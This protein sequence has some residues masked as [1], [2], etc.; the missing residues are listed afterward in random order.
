MSE[1]N[2]KK[3]PSDPQPEPAVENEQVEKPA[4]VKFRVRT[5]IKAGPNSAAC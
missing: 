1:D 2:T 3:V 5:G 4:V